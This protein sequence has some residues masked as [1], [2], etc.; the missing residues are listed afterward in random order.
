M[1]ANRLRWFLLFL[2]VSVVFQLPAQQSDAD[3][4]LQAIKEK[5]EQALHPGAQ[6]SEADR[7]LLADIRAKAEEGDAQSQYE[8]GCAFSFG[9]FG[10]T[11]DEVEAVRWFRK[12]AEQNL[13]EAQARLGSCCCLGLGVA[14]DHV[15]AL[16]W[17]RKA[18]EQNSPMAQCWLG[19]S[20]ANGQGVAKDEA[21]AVKWYRKAAEQN[22][23]NAQNSLGVCYYNGQGVA[24]DEVQAVKWYR[25]SA[26]Q[27]HAL[28][29][30]NRI[31]REYSG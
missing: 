25:K 22:A 28:A 21:E 12:A 23:A 9:N 14:K 8:L 15:E 2:L 11:K 27:N 17:F 18:A 26:E 31:F 5:F 13:A 30:F 24:K 10:V 1:K 29:Q 19:A 16:K 7:K 20:Y 3:R 4:E 6:Q